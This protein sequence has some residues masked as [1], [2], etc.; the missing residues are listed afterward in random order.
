MGKFRRQ[1]INVLI[2]TDILNRGIDIPDAQL[3]INFDIPMNKQ[4]DKKVG[5]WAGYMHRIGR[6]GRFG[7]EAIALSL[8]DRDD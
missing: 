8:Y 5:D 2:C 6:C 1:E 7:S 3:V 4:G